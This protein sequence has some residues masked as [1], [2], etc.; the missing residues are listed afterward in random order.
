MSDYEGQIGVVPLGVGGLFTDAA[1]CNIPATSLIQASNLTFYNGVLEK[2]F[3]SRLWNEDAAAGLSILRI[4]EF[5]PFPQT[6]R[7]F[8]ILRYEPGVEVLTNFSVNWFSRG[9]TAGKGPLIKYDNNFTLT[10]VV[11]SDGGPEFLTSAGYTCMLRCGNEVTNRPRLL[12]V[13]NGHDPVQV[14]TADQNTRSTISDPPADWSGSNQ[15]FAGIL[16]RNRVFAWGAKNNPHQVYASSA[17]NHQDFTTSSLQ[18][19]VYPGEGEYIVGGCVFRG[20]MFVA[21]YPLG[22]YYLVDDDADEANWYFAKFC[23]D[24]GGVS[25]QGWT[26]ANDD[27]VLANSFGSL[28]SLAAAFKFG[29]FTTADIFHQMGVRRYTADQV[30]PDVVLYRDLIF[31][32]YKRQYFAA[33]QSFMNPYPD[34]IFCMDIRNQ[35]SPKISFSDKDQPNCLALIRDNLQIQRPFYGSRNGGIYQ[36]DQQDRWVGPST[37]DSGLTTNQAGYLMDAQTPHMDFSQGETLLGSQV[38]LFDF[39]QLVYEPTGNW[40]VDILVYIDSRLMGTYT[41]NL[42]GRSNLDQFPLTNSVVDGEVG[43]SDRIPIYGEGKCISLRFQQGGVGQNAR[44]VKAYIYYRLSGQQQT[45]SR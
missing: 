45:T 9:V 28:T 11:S 24:F 10:E 33:Y 38:K 22:V 41:V 14:V 42:S 20:R 1:Q 18:F 7:V 2:D 15:P 29:D 19:S 4:Q 44:L 43:F 35:E 34:R 27:V 26:V 40:N 8:A 25:P 12:F 5:F 16:H 37:G 6:Q 13:M 21:K 23:D 3:G 30:R 36:M 39:I 17:T 32:P 31:Y